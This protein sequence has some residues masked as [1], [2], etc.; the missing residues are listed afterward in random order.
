MFIRYHNQYDKFFEIYPPRESKVDKYLTDQG[1]WEWIGPQGDR[2]E[3]RLVNPLPTAFNKMIDLESDPYVADEIGDWLLGNLDD[4]PSFIVDVYL[5]AELA[6]ELV[7][8]FQQHSEVSEAVCCFQKYPKL[9]RLDFAIGDLGI[10]IRQSLSINSRFEYLR[11]QDHESAAL[12]AF[13]DN[14]TRRQEGGTGLGTV[15]RDVLELGGQLFLTTGNAWV[16]LG[17]KIDG[18]DSGLLDM[19]LPGVQIEVSIPAEVVI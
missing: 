18:F 13:D 4:D 8:N 15:R 11:D 12:R 14:V 9:K 17:A 2:H 10:G 5:V 6:T 1:F 16:Q 19:E 7:D 3:T